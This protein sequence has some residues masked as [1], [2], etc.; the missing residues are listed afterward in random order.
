MISRSK[1]LKNPRFS[2][3][4]NKA[5]VLDQLFTYCFPVYS[6]V[7]RNCMIGVTLC[8]PMLETTRT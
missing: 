1:S 5:S 3:V 7:Y 8:A 4:S 6:V 2:L